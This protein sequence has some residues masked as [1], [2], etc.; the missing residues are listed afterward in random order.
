MSGTQLS[1]ASTTTVA[2][3]AANGSV[4][5]NA[6]VAAF[7]PTNGLLFVSARRASTSS[8]RRPARSWRRFPPRAWA[9]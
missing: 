3:N 4:A 9:R 1:A 5:L 7:D 6:E 2:H 8:T